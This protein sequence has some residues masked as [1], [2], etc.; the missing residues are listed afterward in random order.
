MKGVCCLFEL[1]YPIKYP[2]SFKSSNLLCIDNLY[3]NKN[4]MFFNSS[5]V[6][7]RIF[8]HHSVI[9]TML[10][11]TFCKSPAKF[12]YCS[13]YKNYNK[14]HFENVLKQR[15]ASSSNFEEFFDTILATLNEHAPLKEK[16]KDIIIKYLWVKHFVTLSL[17]NLSYELHSTRKDLLKTDKL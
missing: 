4:T 3:P 15:W 16:K 9:C 2:T 5:T 13:S 11:S 12:I 6:E 1:N 7:T 10:C 14:E 8:D 17:N